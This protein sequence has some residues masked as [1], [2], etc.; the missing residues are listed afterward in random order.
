M[1]FKSLNGFEFF[2]EEDGR[3]NVLFF[4]AGK[5][6]NFSINSKEGLDNLSAIKKIFNLDSI[7]YCIQTHSDTVLCYDGSIHE[8]DAVI[9]NSSN[10]GLGVFTAD[11]VPVIIIDKKKNAIA[12]VHSGWKGTYNEI[13]SKTIKN[14]ELYY[15]S[16]P[17]DIEV[18]IGPH[19]GECCYEVSSDIIDSFQKKGYVIEN[20]SKGNKLSLE[21][22]IIYQCV[23]AGV[24]IDNIK[25]NNKCTMCSQEHKFYSYRKNK[26]NGRL[27]SLVFIKNE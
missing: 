24:Q 5:N 12:A 4:T 10:I 25:T 15:K 8:G 11:C 7:G 6:A 26:D 1:E 16:K 9:T 17:E 18:F 27:L 13:T 21:S 2:H 23:Q 3:F 22:C 20:T 14:M 19:I